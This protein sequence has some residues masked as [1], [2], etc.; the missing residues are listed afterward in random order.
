MCAS[1]KI[2]QRAGHMENQV[3]CSGDQVWL[4]MPESALDTFKP[5]AYAIIRPNQAPL[6]CLFYLSVKGHQRERTR[7]LFWVFSQCNNKNPTFF[8]ERICV[9]SLL[10]L[11][12][13][14]TGGSLLLLVGQHF[15]QAASV[16]TVGFPFATGT[17]MGSLVSWGTRGS[18]HGSP[19][20]PT[21]LLI[22]RV[23]QPGGAGVP[24]QRGG[25]RGKPQSPPGHSQT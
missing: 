8:D 25:F 4:N 3:C 18:M 5:S 7:G 6:E 20:S 9:M 12:A 23:A 19:R 21:H 16:G 2:I 15:S 11:P 1:F 14:M 13:P 17:A 22:P 24:P 10:V